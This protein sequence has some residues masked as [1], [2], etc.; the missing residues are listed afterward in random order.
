MLYALL[1]ESNCI[2]DRAVRQL[3]EFSTCL[4]VSFER[5]FQSITTRTPQGNVLALACAV[6]TLN[7]SCS[8]EHVHER[9]LFKFNLLDCGGRKQTR[10]TAHTNAAGFTPACH[11]PTLSIV[12]FGHVS[13]HV[14]GRLAL[15]LLAQHNSRSLL[16]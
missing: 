3:A 14:P 7:T 2:L 9:A 4:W 15:R 5:Y 1:Q 13:V 11:H 8:H 12:V 6:H 10:L 16:T